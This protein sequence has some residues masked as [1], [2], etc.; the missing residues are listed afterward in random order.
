MG[1]V[2]SGHMLLS[3]L[4]G[5]L[6]AAMTNP[7]PAFRNRPRKNSIFETIPET[8]GSVALRKTLLLLLCGKHVEQTRLQ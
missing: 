1:L 4:H 6:W 2:F 5:G 8:C 3:K 7:V